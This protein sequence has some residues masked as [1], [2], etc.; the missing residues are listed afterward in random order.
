MRLEMLYKDRY[1]K[2]HCP[3]CKEVVNCPHCQVAMD[4]CENCG[5]EGLS[6]HVSILHST[7]KYNGMDKPACHT[8][9]LMVGSANYAVA[10]IDTGSS[11]AGSDIAH[12]DLLYIP[13]NRRD[14]PTA[15]II[16]D[17]AEWVR[18][19]WE[20][21]DKQSNIGTLVRLMG[22]EIDENYEHAPMRFKP[23]IVLHDATKITKELLGAA[24]RYRTSKPDNCIE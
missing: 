10:Y 20:S 3:E 15:K 22:F 21:P 12:M 7:E 16:A 24:I 4:Y 14:D 9:R 11:D 17:F 8:A 2:R 5:S 23:F 19:E 18:F 6:P 13:E 1:Q